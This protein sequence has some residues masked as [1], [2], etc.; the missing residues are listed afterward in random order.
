[1]PLTG[2]DM[3]RGWSVRS[4]T[5]LLRSYIGR[6]PARNGSD[7]I[8]TSRLGRQRTP[9]LIGTPP[10]AHSRPLRA[11]SPASHSLRLAEI[12]CA[13]LGSSCFKPQY[14]DKNTFESTKPRTFETHLLLMFQVV[15]LGLSKSYSQ[16]KI[17]CSVGLTSSIH[18]RRHVYRIQ[19]R[20][21]TYYHI[22]I[23]RC[24]L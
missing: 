24:T 4:R 17:K 9:T 12:S 6:F 5:L 16:L 2:H 10:W 13:S 23:C 11:S 1:M 20:I 3:C 21:Y 22:H 18:L 15:T 14:M 8:C 19:Y 7:T